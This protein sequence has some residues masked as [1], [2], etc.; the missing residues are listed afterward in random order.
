MWKLVVVSLAVWSAV[1][2]G[3]IAIAHAEPGESTESVRFE[4]VL[5]ADIAEPKRPG[6][7]WLGVKPRLQRGGDE[8][9]TELPLHF[10]TGLIRDLGLEIVLPYIG[11][12]EDGTAGLGDLQVTLKY[13]LLGDTVPD[14][15]LALGVEAGFPTGKD[16]DDFSRRAYSLGPLALF[17]ARFHSLESHVGLEASFPVATES[18]DDVETSER[19]VLEASAAA[20]Y[21]VREGF[22]LIGEL[23]SERIFGEGRFASSG[24]A[25]IWLEPC[26]VV[27]LGLGI[28]VPFGPE[29]EA[30][31]G[32]VSA[33]WVRF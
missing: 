10:E 16:A 11:A 12:G 33:L 32:L 25:G 28:D 19:N 3:E 22:G 5:V 13:D 27:E 26:E 7:I 6:E 24:V 23:H 31:W 4:E 29:R 9:Q 17:S 20:H 18:A 2:R 30:D 8:W 15:A 1:P 21:R 14:Y